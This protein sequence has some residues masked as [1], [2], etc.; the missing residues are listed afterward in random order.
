MR[1]KIIF[2]IACSRV[3]KASFTTQ[4]LARIKNLIP[5]CA[6]S[7]NGALL[8]NSPRNQWALGQKF[9]AFRF[10]LYQSNR[11]YYTIVPITTSVKTTD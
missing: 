6:L 9:L 10:L 2:K 4:T 3:L 11:F 1:K 5:L 7:R 8:E